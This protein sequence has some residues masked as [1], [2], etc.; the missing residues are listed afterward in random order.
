MIPI[1]GGTGG[2]RFFDQILPQY[3]NLTLPELKEI[4]PELYQQ[5]VEL[6]PELEDTVKLGPSAFEGI[7]LDPATRQAQMD[8]LSRLEQIGS[9]ELSLM[10]RANL[11]QIENEVNR[12]LK[13]NQDA[14]MQ[15]LATRG[16]S[17]GGN[18]LVSRQMATQSATNRQADMDMRVRAEAEQRALQALMQ[19]GQIA[20]QMEQADY[21]RKANVAQNQDAISRFNAQN[22]QNVQQRNVA[23][24][25]N[26]QQWNAQNTQNTYN[27]N[28]GLRNQTQMYNE[29]TRKQQMY[30]NQFNRANALAGAY[31]VRG[32]KAQQDQMSDK[33]DFGN[34][35]QMMGSMAMGFSDERV[36][37]NVSPLDSA[38]FLKHL[39]GYEYEYKDPEAHGEGHQVGIM[40]QDLEKVAP[41]AVDEDENGVKRIDYSKMGGPMLAAMSDLDKRMKKLE[42]EE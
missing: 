32:K 37:K 17:G 15:N 29:N 28:V 31:Q 40:A 24:K 26:T 25:N 12:N 5:V 13:G 21:A 7:T 6:N 8:A 4:N 3:Q 11:N 35:M 10:D 36:K 22:Q 16:M 38:E 2:N 14:I 42:G 9:G 20:S 41:Q 23:N 19:R 30:D 33:E 18:E 1:G 27:Q 34:F 39:D